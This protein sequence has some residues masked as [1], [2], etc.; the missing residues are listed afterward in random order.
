MLR[1]HALHCVAR[2][3]GVAVGLN[4]WLDAEQETGLCYDADLSRKLFPA[5]VPFDTAIAEMTGRQNRER[6]ASR[7]P[8]TF[9]K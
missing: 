9:G 2:L 7:F 1:A 5:R 3:R 6:L 8:E 4:R